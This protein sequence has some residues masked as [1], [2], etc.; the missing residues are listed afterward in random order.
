M[1][2]AIPALKIHD[3]E[4]I[5]VNAPI[6][7]GKISGNQRIFPAPPKSVIS[8]VCSQTRLVLTKQDK[9]IKKLMSAFRAVD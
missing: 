1:S 7:S 2:E 9:T 5:S 3:L 8:S 4:N 6:A